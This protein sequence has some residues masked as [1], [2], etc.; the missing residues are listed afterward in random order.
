VQRIVVAGVV[1]AIVAIALAVFFLRD[2]D[3]RQAETAGVPESAAAS[4][5]S[6]AAES[7]G[8]PEQTEASGEPEQAEAAG[9][10]SGATQT[11]RATTSGAEVVESATEPIGTGTAALP[12]QEAPAGVVP[13]F[14]V[15]RV[16]PSGEAVIAGIAAPNSTVILLDG[17]TPIARV[18]ADV[19][20]AWVIVLDEPLNPGDHQ[21]GLRAEEPGGA[22][23]LSDTVVVVS[24]PAP[25]AVAST[26]TGGSAAAS[27][28]TTA[29]QEPAAEPPTEALPLAVLVPRE[30]QGASRILQQPTEGEGLGDRELV[31][32]AV[33]YN[34]SGFVVISGR[35]DPSARVIIYL[36][37]NA[38]G[39][40]VAGDDGHW[41]V[42][43][44]QPVS[45]GLHRLRVDRV[46]AA[47][48]VLARVATMFAREELTE[49]F[50]Q[51][52]F[53][54]VQPGNS[55][56]RIA[57][58]TY[59]EGI[60]YSVIY[61]ANQGQIRDPDLIYPGQIFVVPTTN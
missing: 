10:T 35:A 53:V 38:I 39:Y 49:G 13:R 45:P 56:W 17:D 60:R 31:L 54:I 21:L 32:D 26:E 51:N 15:V 18:T 16:E 34:A 57:R 50:P 2:G 40:G 9:E 7:T 41:Q 6:G 12:P 36:D 46:D 1:V 59:G 22:V 11:V 52:R 3:D 37:D 30:G 58:R 25:A 24:V 44:T 20:G 33:D 43:P 8:E 55:L 28:E 47:G 4:S 29:A 48:T 14:D 27:T 42:A 5:A 61:Q 23:R 19:T